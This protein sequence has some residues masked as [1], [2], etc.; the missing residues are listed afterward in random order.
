MRVAR[1]RR[2][3]DIQLARD[4]G[5]SRAD[6]L[7][8]M[9]ARRTGGGEVRV[10]VASP[11][12]LGGAVVRNRARRRLREAIRLEIAARR[13]APGTDLFV[14]ARAGAL[15]TPATEL[16]AAVARHLEAVM[17]VI[18]PAGSGG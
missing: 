6:R 7:F 10:A 4:E 2:T 11:R 13:S 12:A 18:E 3:K 15:D 8:S 17:G 9:R 14:V 5:T 1:L 16:R